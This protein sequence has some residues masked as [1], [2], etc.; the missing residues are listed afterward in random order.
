MKRRVKITVS[1]HPTANAVFSC[2]Q[3]PIREKI[4]K[5][6]F[7]DLHRVMIV[8]PGGR[9]EEFAVETIDAC[10]APSEPDS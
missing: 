7:G 2:K 3:I 9:I 1:K 5:R 10:D 8:I 4:L 6:L